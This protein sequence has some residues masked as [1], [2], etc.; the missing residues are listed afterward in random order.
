VIHTTCVPYEGTW[1]DAV[2]TLERIAAQSEDTGVLADMSRAMGAVID[3][4]RGRRDLIQ[5]RRDREAS[6]DRKRQK[7][8]VSQ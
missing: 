1:E 4:A 5:Q 2:A 6:G 7:A 8:G 3:V